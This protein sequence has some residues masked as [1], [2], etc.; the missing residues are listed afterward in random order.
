MVGSRDFRY[1]H[2]VTC[3]IKEF[4]IQGQDCFHYKICSGEK[5]GRE[6]SRELYCIKYYS[7]E[8]HSLSCNRGIFMNHEISNINAQCLLLQRQ[9]ARIIVGVFYEDMARR[10]FCQVSLCQGH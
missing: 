6:R 8:H 3:G 2:P 7:K 1:L 9:D 5:R 4:Q 10:V